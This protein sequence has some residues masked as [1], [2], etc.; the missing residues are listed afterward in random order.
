VVPPL[1]T[2]ALSLLA[3]HTDWLSMR[4]PLYMNSGSAFQFTRPDWLVKVTPLKNLL[5]PAVRAPAAI[6]VLAAGPA[7]LV[8]RRR[9]LKSSD[10]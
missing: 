10:G 9:F 3:S 5:A 4:A 7:G 8:L 1:L 6:T 2:S